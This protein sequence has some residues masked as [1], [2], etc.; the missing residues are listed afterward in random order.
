MAVFGDQIGPPAKDS[1]G[2]GRYIPYESWANHEDIGECDLILLYCTGTY[3]GYDK[4][5]PGV[6][7]VRR[8]EPPAIYYCYLPL[9]KPISLDEMRSSFTPVDKNKLNNLRFNAF[10]I[11][12]ISDASFKQAIKS[13]C[14][15]WSKM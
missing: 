11:F 8:V 2:S 9:D 13:H 6:G 15:D 5:V 4:E 3:I 7:V 12:V 14:L 1:V 10:R